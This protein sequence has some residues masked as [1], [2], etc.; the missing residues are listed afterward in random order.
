MSGN[1]AEWTD[2]NFEKGANDFVAGLNPNVEGSE[3]NQRKVVRGGSWKDVAYFMQLG[4]RDYEYQ[5]TAK[6]YIG[7]RTVQSFL[8]RDLKDF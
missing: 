5:D 1:V 4:A 7:F 2:S 6:S 3:D 8:G